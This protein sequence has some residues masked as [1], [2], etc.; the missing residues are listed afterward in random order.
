VLN[1]MLLPQQTV[2]LAG[3][4]LLLPLLLLLKV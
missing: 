4:L 3:A 2:C 1:E